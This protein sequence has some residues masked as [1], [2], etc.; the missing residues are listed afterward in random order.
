MVLHP[1][2]KCHLNKKQ[3][4]NLRN[5]ASSWR[6]DQTSTPTRTTSTQTEFQE[7]QQQPAQQQ[8]E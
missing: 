2:A 1:Q 8:E 7:D 3:K 6:E 4:T 5:T